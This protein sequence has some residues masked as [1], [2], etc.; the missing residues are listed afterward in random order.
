MDRL[1]T[2]FTTQDDIGFMAGPQ[3]A[4]HQKHATCHAQPREVERTEHLFIPDQAIEDIEKDKSAAT[5]L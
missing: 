5:E 4:A 3:Q 2:V 1:H